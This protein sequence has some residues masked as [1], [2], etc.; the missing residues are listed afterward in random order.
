MSAEEPRIE[1][2]IAMAERLI[3]ALEGDIA[4][5]ERGKPGEMRTIDPEIQ[6]LS[7]LYGREAAGLNAEAAKSAPGELR[8]RLAAI[9]KRFAETL[10][11][12]TRHLTRVK[13]ASEG[14]IRA[15]AEEVDKKRASA[16]P[17]ARNPAQPR[18]VSAMI[19]NNVI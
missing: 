11:R 15:I 17:Y 12:H 16:R 6:K 19:Y 14:M 1:R 3:E 4:A 8:T 2:L 9:T 18:P 13:N 5:L 7:A 10:A